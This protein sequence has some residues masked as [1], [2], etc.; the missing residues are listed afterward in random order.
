MLSGST[1]STCD[2]VAVDLETTGCRPG[3]NSI[4][5]VGAV[6]FTAAGIVSTFDR[7]V[8]PD[9]AI[10]RAVEELT[11]ITTGMVATAPEIDDVIVEF[12][13]FAR[14]AVLVAHNYRFDLSFL[15]YEA[16]RAWGSPFPRP[17]IDTLFVL[18]RLRPDLRRF[19]LGSL[20]EAY[21]LSTTPDHRACNDARATAELLQAVLPDLEKLG[22]RTAGDL[23]AFSGLRGQSDLAA[24]L[25]LTRDVPDAPGVYLF[26]DAEGRVIYVGH[27]RSLRTR[28]RQYFY[29]GAATDK[30]AHEVASV[31]AVR[32]P[33]Q[34]DALLLEHRLVDRHKPRF[35]PPAHRSRVGYLVKAD[36]NAPFSGLRV[37]EAPRS[38]GRLIGPFTSKW[39]ATTL[40]ERLQAVYELRRC[41]RKLDARLALTPCP[42][43]DAGVCPAPCVRIA[44]P[45]TYA[46]RLDRALSVFEDDADLRERL[47][48]GQRAAAAEGRYEEAIRDRDGLRALDRAR[49]TVAT[50][51]QA[52]TRDVVFVEEA[53]GQAVVSF[54]RGGLR[55]AVL[56]GDRETIGPKVEGV[57]Q[58]VYF[59]GAAAVDPL[60]LTPE[61]LAELL[62]IASFEETDAHMEIQVGETAATLAG[63][64]RALGLDRRVPRRR[65]AVLSAG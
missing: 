32:T 13:E 62:I 23:A 63:I 65:H 55:A 26:R 43:R 54:I 59:S 47:V 52:A 11:H 30:L 3:R 1:L 16:D 31:T 56:R 46:E 42:N 57:L 36:A 2:L 7:F 53:D 35:N 29:P 24:R 41:S 5:E 25:H 49:S 48:S 33:S 60:Q 19:S 4:I 61:K 20:A 22:V 44:D 15:D 21:G 39:A 12:A 50:V 6:R 64:R 10:P 9:E 38:R 8:R 14:G 27:A 17:V 37:C 18:R 40:V 34:L 28:T 45:D 58:R 51:R